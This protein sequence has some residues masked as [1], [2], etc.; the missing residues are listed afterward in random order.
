MKRSG[1]AGWEWS[2]APDKVSFDRSMVPVI[3]KKELPVDMGVRTG[4]DVLPVLPHGQP[5]KYRF[6]VAIH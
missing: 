4:R 5:L 2:V 6:G 1:F 3:K